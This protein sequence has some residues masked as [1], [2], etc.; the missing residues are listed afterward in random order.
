MGLVIFGTVL[1]GIIITNIVA[2]ERKDIRN[3]K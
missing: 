3:G 1:F 2:Q